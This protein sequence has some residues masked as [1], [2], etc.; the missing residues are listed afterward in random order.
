MTLL[1]M[2]SSANGSE[3]GSCDRTLQN[4]QDA[5][6][7]ITAG[8]QGEDAL[9]VSSNTCDK[10]T[11]WS[12]AI[13]GMGNPFRPQT[14]QSRSPSRPSVVSRRASTS[15]CSQQ[16]EQQLQQHHPHL[17]HHAPPPVHH[18]HLHDPHLQ[19]QYDLAS[20]QHDNILHSVNHSPSPA[21]TPGSAER[22]NKR[23]KLT[24]RKPTIAS[25]VARQ[26]AKKHDST[27][28][29]RPPTKLTEA[30]PHG[31]VV[32]TT[33]GVQTTLNLTAGGLRL[34]GGSRTIT[35]E[36]SQGEGPQ[37]ETPHTE[38]THR[39]TPQRETRKAADRRSLRSHGEGPRLKSELAVYFP[40][41]EEVIY[42]APKEPG[43][44]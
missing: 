40:D 16:Q 19:Q 9:H 21:T 41:Y 13:F 33:N 42:D 23:L 38:T 22:S 44:F 14:R 29:P 12:S 35:A 2:S 32:Q 10:G 31:K 6:F 26:A 5:A 15:S 36:V 4:F 17:Q 25:P 7:A 30:Q 1:W 28:T 3:R 24:V 39:E 8:Q 20:L 27:R 18:H 34:S 37:R 43:M 11:R